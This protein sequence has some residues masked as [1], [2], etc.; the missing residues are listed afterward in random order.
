MSGDFTSEVQAQ[1]QQLN[2][3]LS[4]VQA[5]W[6]PLGIVSTENGTDM[7]IHLA[8]LSGLCL[9]LD[10]NAQAVDQHLALMRQGAD[11][12]AALNALAEEQRLHAENRSAEDDLVIKL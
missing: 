9:G 12:A 1:I 6:E 8:V 7:A 10:D 2:E 11:L 4:A 5:A 3:L